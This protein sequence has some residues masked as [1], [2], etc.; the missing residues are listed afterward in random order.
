MVREDDQ[1]TAAGATPSASATL[2]DASVATGRTVGAGDIHRAVHHR[3]L[4][5]SHDKPVLARHADRMTGLNR[6]IVELED[7]PVSI[8]GSERHRRSTIESN[9]SGAGVNEDVRS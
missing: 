2:P 9:C 1:D 6:K 3:I 5:R 8:D 7:D 4:K